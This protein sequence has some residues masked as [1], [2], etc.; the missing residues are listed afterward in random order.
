MRLKVGA[1]IFALVIAALIGT[2]AV[3]WDFARQQDADFVRE[4]RQ[5]VEASLRGR[6][7]ALSNTTKDF[8]FW[9]EAYAA[10]TAA[11]DDSW[12]TDNVYSSAA[13]GMIV[14]GAG[15]AIR[16]AWFAEETPN[17]ARASAPALARAAGSAARLR[18]AARAAS[19]N[20]STW[21]AMTL[22]GGELALLATA[23]VSPEDENAR[24]ARRAPGPVHYF[25]SIDLIDR[26]EFQTMSETLGLEGIALSTAPPARDEVALDLRDAEGRII[27]RLTWRNERPGSAGFADQAWLIVAM[28]VLLG[29]GAA[30][31]ASTLIAHQMQAMAHAEAENESN[32]SKSET[33][34][35]IANEL[36][37]PLNAMFSN[38]RLMQTRIKDGARDTVAL[39]ADADRMAAAARR[40]L[41]QIGRLMDEA[42]ID[43]GHFRPAVE[44]VDVERVAREAADAAARAARAKG[45][46]IEVFADADAG[47]ASADRMRV[48]QCV[49][50]LFWSG[51][52]VC[53]SRALNLHVMRRTDGD[54]REIIAFDLSLPGADAP[55]LEALFTPQ[56]GRG[57]PLSLAR[58]LAQ[59]M[60]G[61]LTAG[62]GASGAMLTLFVP[63]LADESARYA[64]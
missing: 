36:R 62:A 21:N 48:T 22:A 8:A 13:D 53:D 14:F 1:P 58:K 24:G 15:R 34:A 56:S 51:L 27:A 9:D 61:D 30:F 44:R 55:T 52:R 49:L 54:G 17:A 19:P 64:A 59:A 32:R 3:F 5:L 11:P 23:P 26:S 10:I 12:I 6:A 63:A 18:E 45:L 41:E 40:M 2:L 42:Q 29:L 50:A 7:R 46:T 31:A 47:F 38:A 28:G 33:I 39:A 16:Y 25:T 43:S 35:L 20:E 60:G 57:A 37:A 4:S